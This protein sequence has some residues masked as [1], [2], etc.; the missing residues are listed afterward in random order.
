M[1]IVEPQ[2]GTRAVLL[3]AALAVASAASHGIPQTLSSA[4]VCVRLTDFAGLS[5]HERAEAEGSV[6]WVFRRAR[7]DIEFVECLTAAEAC[8]QPKEPRDISLQIL[9]ERPKKMPRDTAGFTVLTP[10]DRLSDSYA[11]VS[12]AVVAAKA[13]QMNV[14]EVDVLAAAIAHELGHLLLRTSS[15]ARTGIMKQRLDREQIER[16]ERGTLLFTDREAAAMT[17]RLRP[18]QP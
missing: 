10:S 15:H 4:K 9:K 7:V 6:Q 8:R 5:G 16:M 11:V 2:R 13:R 14:P 1:N 17:A 12:F 18:P 3:M